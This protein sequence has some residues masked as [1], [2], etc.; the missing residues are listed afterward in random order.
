V[1]AACGDQQAAF[2]AQPESLPAPAFAAQGGSGFSTKC[3]F[4]T[5]NQLAGSYFTNNDTARVVRNLINDMKAAGAG[6]LTARNLGFDVFI[7]VSKNLAA[8]PALQTGSAFVNEIIKCMFTDPNA[9]PASYTAATPGPENFTVSLDATQNGAFEVRGGATGDSLEPVRARLG[10]YSAVAPES[11]SWNGVLSTNPAPRRVLFYG[12]S[13]T[14][15][16]GVDPATFYDWKVIARNTVF[17]PKVVVGVCIDAFTND[18]GNEKAM[19]R[20]QDQA[21]AGYLQFAE[22]GFL[23]PGSTC[24]GP[25]AAAAGPW[26]QFAQG[27]LRIGAELF[28]PRPLVA[29]GILKL[30]GLG[31]STGGIGT[32]YG[33][34]FVDSV[35]LNFVI[36]PHDAKVCTVPA[37]SGCSGTRTISPVKVLATWK[38]IPVGGVKITVVPVDNNGTPAEMRGDSTLVTGEDG[39]VTY[40]NL[41]LTKPGGYRLFTVAELVV[42]RSDQIVIP[43]VSS[44]RFNI[45]P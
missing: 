12:R 35:F 36:Q 3:S 10:S 44:T 45:R 6:S 20:R 27:M 32:D 28:G 43:H 9:W 5:A 38:G 15:Q 37:G 18:F 2:P 26:Q 8:N 4:Q 33:P 11:G 39:T 24:D 17:N 19:V 41:G 31:G 13:S 30:G 40:T 1:V 23:V 16:P 42:S 34:D 25:T 14:G 21:G 7:H 22:A 29:S